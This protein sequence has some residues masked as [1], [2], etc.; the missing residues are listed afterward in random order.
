LSGGN[1]ELHDLTAFLA[2]AKLSSHEGALRNG[3]FEEVSD[4]EQAAGDEGLIALGLKKP[5][6]KRLR[7]YLARPQEQ[8]G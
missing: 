8:W 2:G 6:V 1:D 7:R 3:G 4:L 5:E